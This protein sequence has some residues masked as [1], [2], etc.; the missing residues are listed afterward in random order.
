MLLYL[1]RCTP[2]I[3]F[4]SC[5]TQK[6]SAAHTA[7]FLGL[8]SNPMMAAARQPITVL[9]SKIPQI[10]MKMAAARQPIT[11]LHSKLAQIANYCVLRH[12][13]FRRSITYLYCYFFVIVFCLFGLRLL[14]S[15]PLLYYIPMITC[16]QQTTI[17]QLSNFSS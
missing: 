17:H 3:L 6:S 1:H 5:K 10:A 15:S 11:V 9:H 12:M 4:E 16:F 13:H 2:V 7:T 8:L 14:I